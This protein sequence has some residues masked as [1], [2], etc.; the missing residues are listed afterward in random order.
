PRGGDASWMEFVLLLRRLLVGDVARRNKLVTRRKC[1]TDQA[2]A[3][4]HAICEAGPRS[5]PGDRPCELGG[6]YQIPPMR[7]LYSLCYRIGG[8]FEGVVLL[9]A[10]SLQ[11][12][13]QWLS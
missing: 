9:E 13:S 10:D 2:G 6:R 3:L 12:P 5:Y 4:R 1:N 7:S 11:L 8:S